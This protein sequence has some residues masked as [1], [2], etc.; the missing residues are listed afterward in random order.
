MLMKEIKEIK[1]IQSVEVQI[2]I[3]KI[4]TYSKVKMTYHNH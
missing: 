2:K 4:F 1:K 3:N